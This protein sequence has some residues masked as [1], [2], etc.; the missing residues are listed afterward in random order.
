MKRCQ[1]IESLL[2]SERHPNGARYAS[3][4]AI[5]QYVKAASAS[6]RTKKVADSAP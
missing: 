1:E 3:R 5:N 6:A 2:M 4:A